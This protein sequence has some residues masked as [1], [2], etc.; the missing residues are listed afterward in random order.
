M[1]GC[2]FKKYLNQNDGNIDAGRGSQAGDYKAG[3]RKPL[4]QATI[5]EQIPVVPEHP[6]RIHQGGPDQTEARRAPF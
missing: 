2:D 1:S 5:I 4:Q 6:G 3:R